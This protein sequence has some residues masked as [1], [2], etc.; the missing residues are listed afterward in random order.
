MAFHVPTL[1]PPLG[2]PPADD[3]PGPSC[4]QWEAE[5]IKCPCQGV[6]SRGREVGDGCE[7]RPARGPTSA[8][9][10]SPVHGP[11]GPTRSGTCRPRSLRP[12]LPAPPLTSKPSEWPSCHVTSGHLSQ[13]SPEPAQVSFQHCPQ[14]AVTWWLPCPRLTAPRWPSSVSAESALAKSAM[15]V[16]K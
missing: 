4:G 11:D 6:A 5:N 8:E 7:P 14:P 13:G 15:S 9:T 12:L 1:T 3:P 2:P 10:Q 16:L